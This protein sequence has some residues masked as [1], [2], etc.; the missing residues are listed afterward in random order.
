MG[1]RPRPAGGLGIDTLAGSDTHFLPLASPNRTVGV[2]ALLPGD[3][4]RLFVPEQ[5]RLLDTFA[6]QIAIAIERAPLAEEGRNARVRVETE[7]L[8]NSLLAGISH[9]LRTPL[10]SIVGSASTWPTAPPS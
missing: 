9:D 2:A 6:G 3:P 10:A 4:R 8:R 5:R 7:E 1:V